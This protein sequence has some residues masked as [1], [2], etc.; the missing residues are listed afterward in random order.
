M[1]RTPIIIKFPEGIG[2]E[3]LIRD[4]KTK[5]RLLTE[6]DIKA[7]EGTVER[8]IENEMLLKAHEI[9]NILSETTKKEKKC[10]LKIIET[11]LGVNDLI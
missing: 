4:L 2:I 3:D 5:D 11:V 6:D 8:N 7:M 10:I 1:I 9:I